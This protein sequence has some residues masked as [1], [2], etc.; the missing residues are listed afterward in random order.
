[1]KTFNMINIIK[2]LKLYILKYITLI[3][4]ILIN[5]FFSSFFL[6][7]PLKLLVK[8]LKYNYIKSFMN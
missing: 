7:F 2:I 8:Y 5:F 1:M 4:N 3:Q 6:E